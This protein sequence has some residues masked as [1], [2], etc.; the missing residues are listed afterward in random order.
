M[1]RGSVP[2]WADVRRAQEALEKAVAQALENGASVRAVAELGV[3][4]NT[5]QQ[6]GRVHGWPTGENRERFYEFRDDRDDRDSRDDWQ[7]A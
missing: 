3:S 1:P 5:V 7:R 4:A 2:R 6:Y